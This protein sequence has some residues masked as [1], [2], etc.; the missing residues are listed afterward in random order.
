MAPWDRGHRFEAGAPSANVPRGAD[1]VWRPGPPG[2]A[3]GPEPIADTR[4]RLEDVVH[5]IGLDFGSTTSSAM[6]PAARI[7]VTS[8]TA[9]WRSDGPR[10]CTDPS[11]CSRRFATASSTSTG[12]R[13]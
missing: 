13:S 10:S 8:A 2:D 11:L 5:L 3:V 1:T 9:A 12:S 6:A 4:G 7:A